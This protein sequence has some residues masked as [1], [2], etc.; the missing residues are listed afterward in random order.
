M[1]AVGIVKEKNLRMG[2]TEPGDRIYCLGIPTVGNEVRLNT[3]DIAD[4]GAVKRSCPIKGGGL[5]VGLSVQWEASLPVN[6]EKSTGPAN[7]S[8]LPLRKH[9]K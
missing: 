5:G 2:R 7:V 1:T 8:F 4:A 3:P 9:R 6:T